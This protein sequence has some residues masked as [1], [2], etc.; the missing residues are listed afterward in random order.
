MLFMKMLAEGNLVVVADTLEIDR[1]CR[2]SLNFTEEE[3]AA[4]D[5]GNHTDVQVG[6]LFPDC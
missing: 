3:C 2:V 5:T 4:M 1:V 6:C